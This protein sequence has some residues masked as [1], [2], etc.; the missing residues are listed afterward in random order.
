MN[1][2]FGIGNRL[3]LAERWQWQ[4]HMTPRIVGCPAER[5]LIEKQPSLLH[6]HGYD[7]DDR[8][9]RQPGQVLPDF[10]NPQIPAF[11]LCITVDE[12]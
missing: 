11:S 4:R 3:N 7:A 9:I 8:L 2:G 10:P 6:P 5:G 12:Q 1:Q